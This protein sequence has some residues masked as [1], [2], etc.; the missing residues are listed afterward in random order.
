MPVYVIAR[1][2]V[3]HADWRRDYGQKTRDLIRKHGGRELA[4]FGSKVEVLEPRPVTNRADVD[5]ATDPGM[6]DAIV[7]LEFPSGDHARNWYHDPDYAPLIALRQTGS[8]GD[9]MLVDPDDL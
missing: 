2:D 7:I 8:V 4:R 1:L 5:P 6:P 3:Q 9:L